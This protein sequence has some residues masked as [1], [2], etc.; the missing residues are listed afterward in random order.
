MNSGGWLSVVIFTLLLSGK[1]NAQEPQSCQL[2]RFSILPLTTLPDGR[3]TVPGVANEQS[4]NFLV[5]TG[6]AV[7]TLSNDKAY[8]LG[9]LVAKAGGELRGV[10]GTKSSA[11]AFV[12]NFSLG[13]MQGKNVPFYI[14]DRLPSGAD[15]T[16]SP[17]IMKHYD[18]EID[19][20]RGN[21]N[22]FSPKHCPGKVVYWTSGGYVALPMSVVSG[23]HIEIQVMVDGKKV[24]ALLDTGAVSSIVSLGV[25]RALGIT[26]KSPDLKPVGDKNSSYQLYNYPFKLLD[27]DGITVT[28]PLIQVASD[29]FLPRGTD[30]LIGVSILRRLHLYI[31]YGEEKLYITPAMAH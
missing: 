7:M 12:D 13:L 16:L 3:F 19:P 8:S 22:L 20:A 14:D 25:L 15:G 5:D 4:F 21:I 17:D 9:L 18:V 24:N 29:N 31:A 2:A 6:G 23:G 1:L 27:F 26:E 11:I 10:A 30:M 28:N